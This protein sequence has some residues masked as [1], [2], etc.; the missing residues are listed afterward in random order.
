MRAARDDVVHE[1]I[2]LDTTNILH[3]QKNSSGRDGAFGLS[4]IF[5]SNVIIP[6]T[7]EKERRKTGEPARL[8]VAVHDVLQGE[9][10]GRERRAKKE[11]KEMERERR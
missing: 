6:G 11:I 1:K 8:P 2:R 7:R 10:R 4:G 5:I 9:R 3:R